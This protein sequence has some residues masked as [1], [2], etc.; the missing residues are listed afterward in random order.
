MK[1]SPV[2]RSG[3]AP[4]V[5]PATLYPLADIHPVGILGGM[6]PAAGVDFIRLFLGACESFLRERDVPIADQSFPEHWLAQIPVVDRSRA[7]LDEDAPQPLEELE[8]ALSQL[9]AVG[10][11]AVAIACN[12]A[13]AWH[14][15]LQSNCK[16]VELLHIAR[17]TAARLRD[18][19][20]DVAVLLAT[21]GTY[22]TRL[23]QDAFDACG[24]RC[25]LPSPQ[26]QQTLMEGIFNGVKAGR[27]D[28]A[29]ELFGGVGRALYRRH[30]ALPMVMACTEIPLALPFVEEA[31]DWTLIDPADVLAHALVLRAYG[32]EK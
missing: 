16:D 29:R 27:L 5:A 32:V 7:L 17:E 24:I 14:E 3:A 15:V 21:Q 10:A 13:H 30:G 12:T 18:D 2:F 23:Y 4:A 19:G 8:R 9:T 31:R 20:V 28:L 25:I 11:C 26:E 22:R 6:G 1:A